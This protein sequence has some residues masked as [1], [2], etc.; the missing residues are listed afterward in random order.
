[1][2]F[3]SSFILNAPVEGEFGGFSVSEEGQ[4][5]MTGSR[6]FCE[7]GAR[8]QP[9]TRGDRALGIVFFRFPD[10]PTQRRFMDAVEAHVT[11]HVR[12]VS[13]GSGH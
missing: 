3:R 6:V 9:F 1:M 12:P 7:N 4:R 5:W 11:V 10:V 13:D 8:V 2:L